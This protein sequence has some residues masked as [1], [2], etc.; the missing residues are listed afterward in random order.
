MPTVSSYYCKFLLETGRHQ[1]ALERLVKTFAWRKRK[2]WQVAI[3]T[4][5]LFAS[6]LL[7]LGLTFLARGDL[8]NAKKYLDQQVELFRSADE[9]LYLPTGLHSRARYFIKVKDFQAA[10]ADLNEALQIAQR[11]GAVLG[12]GRHT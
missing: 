10:T 11:T 4:T 6:D 12:N 1:E 7:V 5:S 8:I 9:W 3:D 2:S